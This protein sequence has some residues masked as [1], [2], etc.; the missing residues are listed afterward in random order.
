MNP[1]VE[2]TPLGEMA[3]PRIVDESIEAIVNFGFFSHLNV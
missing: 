1:A 2:V 3:G